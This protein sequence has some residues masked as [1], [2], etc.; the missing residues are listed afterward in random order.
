MGRFMTR[1]LFDKVNRE[2]VI[3][4]LYHGYQCSCGFICPDHYTMD[5][6]KSQA[7]DKACPG[8]LK[9]DKEKRDT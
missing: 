6:H 9:S 4:D 1:E 8:W 2:H 5:Q 3:T 7:F